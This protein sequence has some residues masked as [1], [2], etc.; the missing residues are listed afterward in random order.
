MEEEIWKA[1]PD[2]EGYYE[3]SNLGN[4]RSMDREIS[5]INRW[6]TI[7]VNRLTGKPMALVIQEPSPGY[8]RKTV[9]LCKD[10]K[11]KTRLVHHLVM[12][13]F[14]GPRPSGYE[15]AH[16]NGDSLNNR[17]ANLRYA[18]PLENTHDKYAHGTM[19]RGESVGTAKLT[20]EQVR[21]IKASKGKIK[22]CEL[23]KM[24][25]VRDPAIT[26]IQQGKRWRHVS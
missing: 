2:Y 9:G 1:V 22:G 14:E 24:F 15:V 5:Q 10:N 16:C 3:V 25:G 12:E 21:F 23:A 11:V 18:L 7:S 4:V 13:A 6:G 17:F 20:E 26:R 8:L 19:L